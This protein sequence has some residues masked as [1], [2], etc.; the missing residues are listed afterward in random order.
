[1]KSLRKRS[2]VLAGKILAGIFLVTILSLSVNF[3]IFA[4]DA[5][6]QLTDDSE[7]R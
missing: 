1:M 6:E 4:A 3:Y 7:G 5:Q 2:V